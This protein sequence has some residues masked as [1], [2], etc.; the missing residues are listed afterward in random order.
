M[1]NQVPRLLAD[2]II[3]TKLLDLIEKLDRG[4]LTIKE[5]IDIS[6]IGW[7]G[8]DPDEVDELNIRRYMFLGWIIYTQILNEYI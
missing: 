7:S 8:L 1:S 2:N 6:S 4:L 5:R 3:E